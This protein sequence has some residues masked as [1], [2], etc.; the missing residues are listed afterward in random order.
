GLLA[1]ALF[2]SALSP[3]VLSKALAPGLDRL[4]PQIQGDWFVPAVCIAVGQTITV[5]FLVGRRLARP[6][7]RWLAFGLGAALIAANDFVLQNGYPGIHILLSAAGATVLG[8][9]LA[10]CRSHWLSAFERFRSARGRRVAVSL[11][12]SLAAAFAALTIVVPPANGVQIELLE[13]DTPLLFRGIRRFYGPSR[14]GGSEIPPELRP[15]FEARADRPDIPPT[16]ERFLAEGPIVI[17]ITIDSLRADVLERHRHA[18][19]NLHALRES[20]VYFSQARTS[21]TDTLKS[22]STMLTGRHQSMLTWS[23]GKGWRK[24]ALQNDHGSR[25]G[26]LLRKGG[27]ATVTAETVSMLLPPVGLARGFTEILAAPDETKYWTKCVEVTEL[28][29]ER[30]RRHGSGPLFFYTHFLEPHAPYETYGKP[31][32]SKFDAYLIEISVVDEMIGRIRRA[33]K[34]LGLKKRTALIISADHGEGFGEHRIYT[35]GKALYD[36]LVHVPL[37]VE[38]PGLKPRTIEDF[39]LVMDVA[40]TVLDLFGL[41]TPGNWMAQSLTPLLAGSGG[42]E[43]RP[44]LMELS[45]HRAMLFPDGLKVMKRRGT[46]EI[47]DVRRDPEELHNLW[48]ELGDE[49]KRRLGLLDA[50]VHA[51]TADPDEEEDD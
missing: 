9:S 50:Y 41:P 36:I 40:P 16:S 10:Y 48:D 46:Y 35:H 45:A 6:R 39:V 7:L 23:R 38:L 51:H 14:I 28:L 27:V 18:A 21:S 44:L 2:A 30:L 33:I 49:S 15:W 32:K 24:I 22:L 11:G 19:P 34:S 1:V 3:F 29:I 20:A 43:S 42:S 13:R 31:A 4:F 5:C 37:L 12:W 17:F 25:L 47:Y 26:E 8:A